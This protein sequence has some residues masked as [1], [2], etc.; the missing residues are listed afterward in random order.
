M[1]TPRPRVV[2][3]SGATATGKTALAIDLACALDGELVSAD[4]VALYRRLAIGSARPTDDELHGVAHH[5]AGTLDLRDPYDAA[6]FMADADAAIADIASRGRVALVVGGSGL[7]QRALVR[8]LAMGIPANPTVRDALRARAAEGEAALA[9]MHRELS[10]VD[11]EYAARIH[12]TDPIRIVRALEVYAVSGETLTSHH[13]R[14]AQLP[15]RYDARWWC[16]DVDREALRER[17][18]ARTATMLA[19]GWIDEVRGILADGYEPGLK[20]LRSVGYAEIVAHL[21]GHLGARELPTAIERAT[22]AF[23]KRQRTWF[24]GD[25]DVAWIA[26]SQARSAKAIEE[27]SGWLRR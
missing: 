6:R 14:H 26:P 10:A 5:M 22:M 11:P 18:V 20:P 24:R 9:G 3:L 19:R 1:T 12:P 23:A 13:R 7:Y 4:S 15:P 25:P 16:L 2:V 17:V 27:L 8:G 21:E